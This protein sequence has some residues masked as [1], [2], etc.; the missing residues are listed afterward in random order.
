ME[1]QGL[2]PSSDPSFG[3]KLFQPNWHRVAKPVLGTNHQEMVDR[4]FGNLEE[5]RLGRNVE[6]VSHEY[7]HLGEG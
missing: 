1:Q 7:L 5:I 6:G 3:F 2:F 4:I